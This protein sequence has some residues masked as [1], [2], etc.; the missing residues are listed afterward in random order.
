MKKTLALLVILALFSG[1]STT[2][3]AKNFNGL[4]TP[5]GK[6]VHVSTSNIALH[7]LMTKPLAGDASLEKTVADFTAEAKKEGASKV[8]IVQSNCTKLWFLLP[9]ITFVITPVLSNVA[10]DAIS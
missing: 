5:A 2:T 7:L 1:C 3:V 10:G 8:R 4:D 6:A 9:P